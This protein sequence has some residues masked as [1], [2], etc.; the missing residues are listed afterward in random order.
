MPKAA[1][2]HHLEPTANPAQLD[3]IPPEPKAIAAEVR[4]T[5]LQVHAIFGGINE[6][7]RAQLLE[8]FRVSKRAGEFTE[9]MGKVKDSDPGLW[10]R[11]EAVS[12]KYSMLRRQLQRSVRANPSTVNVGSWWV[13]C[14]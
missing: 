12:Y 8:Y 4:D 11:L 1:K 13:T 7:D 10:L 6:A 9:M 3:F 14:P 5:A 2:I